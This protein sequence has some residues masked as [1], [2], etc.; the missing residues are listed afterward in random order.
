MNA[1]HAIT[2][3]KFEEE[4]NNLQKKSKIKSNQER[5]G[6]IYL[7]KIFKKNCYKISFQKG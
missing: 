6:L 4:V 7:M 1:N 2:A 5:K 3:N